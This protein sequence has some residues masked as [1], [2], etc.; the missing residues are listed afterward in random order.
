[1]GEEKLQDVIN[2]LKKIKEFV[3]NEV[4]SLIEDKAPLFQKAAQKT[5]DQ[6]ENPYNKKL[7]YQKLRFTPT[8]SNGYTVAYTKYKQSKGGFVG[9]VDLKLTGEFYQ[10]IRLE[11]AEKNSFVFTSED[12]KWV[13]LNANYGDVLGINEPILQDLV[14]RNLEKDL[15]N[16]VE[17][18]LK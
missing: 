9:Y 3:S 14:T 6:G 1:M 18:Y 17:N 7:E 16:S 12:E 8:G 10:S 2:K 4:D 15:N 5:L 13:Y 11:K